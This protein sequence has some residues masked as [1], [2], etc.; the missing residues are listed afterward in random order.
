MFA[1]KESFLEFGKNFVNK[2]G[3]NKRPK[4]PADHTLDGQVILITGANR[5][6]GKVVAEDCVNRG[7][8]VVMGCRDVAAGQAAIDD[9]KMRQPNAQM[10]VYQLDLG[11]F[12]SVHSF[13]GAVMQNEPKLDVLLNN[14]AIVTP[15]RTITG[16]GHE[17]TIQVN[18]YSPVLLT[19]LLAPFLQKT[20]SDPRI[21]TVGALGHSYVKDVHYQDMNTIAP[22]FA[23]FNVYL[24]SKLALM[25][26]VRELAIRSSANKGAR[27]YCVDP[28]VSPTE[29]AGKRDGSL[30]SRVSFGLLSTI[31]RPVQEAADSILK[32]ILKEKDGYDPRVYYFLDGCPKALSKTAKD[33]DK[34]AKLWDLT[35]EV[36]PAMKSLGRDADASSSSNHK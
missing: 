1:A 25:M 18:Y 2:V 5:G 36:V 34:T 27:V 17:M 28:G 21:V 13:A 4:P 20:S 15:E 31:G 19:L 9:I 24:H 29:L 30:T 6:M 35:A 23:P 3:I 8:R 33:D 16:D 12:A 32:V 10:A 14:A 7:A 11:S 26:F 22:Q